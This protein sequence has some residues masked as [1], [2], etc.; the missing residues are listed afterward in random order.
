MADKKHWLMKSEP[1]VFSID[2]LKKDK[3]TLWS[4]VR[5]YQARNFMKD[6]N[7]GDEVIFY[8]SSA[9]PSGAVGLAHVSKKAVP[10]PQRGDGQS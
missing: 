4:G 7:V 1:D 3:T 6:M 9:D 10:D 5:N 8:H 2:Q